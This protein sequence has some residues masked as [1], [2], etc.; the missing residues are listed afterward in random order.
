MREPTIFNVSLHR[1]ATQSFTDFCARNGLK[2][3]HWP[4]HAFDQSCAPALATLDT[5]DLW[6]RY[7]PIL[8]GFDAAADLPA[9]VVFREAMT[10]FPHAKFVLILRDPEQWAASVRRH[11]GAR[12]M[13]VL[14]KLQ[15]WGAHGSRFGNHLTLSDTDLTA[16]NQRH[17]R[18]VTAFAQE[19]QVTLGTFTLTDPELGSQLAGFLGVKKSRAFK[20]VDATKPKP[21]LKTRLAQKFFS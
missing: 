2:A 11:I 7:R 15:Y 3:Q 8:A 16:L 21:S 4:G 6:R 10:D 14:E 17:T 9:P 19:R 13:D 20:L 12:E 5:A 18:M 1:S